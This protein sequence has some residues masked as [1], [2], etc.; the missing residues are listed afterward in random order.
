[1]S[2]KLHPICVKTEGFYAKI[3]RHL[4]DISY[5]SEMQKNYF[6]FLLLQLLSLFFLLSNF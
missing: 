2:R 5:L 3:R 6:Q 1:M 4:N